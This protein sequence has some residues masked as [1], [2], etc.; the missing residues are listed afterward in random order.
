M[1]NIMQNSQYNTYWS[2]D[3]P[4]ELKRVKEGIQKMTQEVSKGIRSSNSR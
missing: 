3:I 4:D 2:N 1:V